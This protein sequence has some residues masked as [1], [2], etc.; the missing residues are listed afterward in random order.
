MGRA[1]TVVLRRARNATKFQIIVS[2]VEDETVLYPL[3]F[4][5]S[6][7]TTKGPSHIETIVSADAP[8]HSF[9]LEIPESIP[10]G[11]VLDVELRAARAT[12]ERKSL[13]LRSV[14]VQEIRPLP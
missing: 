14:R 7:P 1:T 6:I 10:V 11:T 5:A 3:E 9:E 13:V 4:S 2:P 8:E 12:L